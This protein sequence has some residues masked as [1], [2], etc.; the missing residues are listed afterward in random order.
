MEAYKLLTSEKFD[1]IKNYT[2]SVFNKIEFQI[3]SFNETAGLN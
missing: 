1:T 2:K 3:K